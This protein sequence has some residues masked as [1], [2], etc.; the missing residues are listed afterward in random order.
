MKVPLALCLLMFAGFVGAQSMYRWVDKEG[1]VHYTDRAPVAG[2]AA[3]VEQKRSVLLGADQTM[4]YALRQAVTDYPV[5]LYTQSDCPPCVD[6]RN[7][8][9][10]RGIPFTEKNAGSD[11]EIAAL[12]ALVGGDQPG[13]PVL[14]VGRKVAKKGY[15]GSDWD[16]LLDSAGYP[17]AA[18]R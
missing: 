2:E 14:Q 16:G 3:K 15:L 1:K 11:A 18:G 4:S 17:K 13:L 10:T 5:T 7:H 6:G 9:N 12:K 8:L